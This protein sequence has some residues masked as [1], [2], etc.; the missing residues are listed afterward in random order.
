ME[1]EDLDNELFLKERKKKKARVYSG[2][3]RDASMLTE[4][5][6]EWMEEYTSQTVLHP[7]YDD[8]NRHVE[9]AV[10]LNLFDMHKNYHN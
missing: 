6:R 10:M 1:L 2:N 3:S 9:R 8:K 7:T 4:Q 5:E